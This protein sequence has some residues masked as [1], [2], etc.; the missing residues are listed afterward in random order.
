MGGGIRIMSSDE[1]LRRQA[2][3]HGHLQHGHQA[4]LGHDGVR[5]FHAQHD[6]DDHVIRDI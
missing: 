3:L 4:L 6:S 5:P 1:L 2:D